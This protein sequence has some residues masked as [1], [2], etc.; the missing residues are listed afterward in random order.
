MTDTYAE[1]IERDTQLHEAVKDS[2][3]AIQALNSIQI[4][5]F[6]FYL[7]SLHNYYP[8][9]ENHTT[10]YMDF[11]RRLDELRNSAEQLTLQ[12]KVMKSSLFGIGLCV[13][14][15]ALLS[16]TV[17]AL[18]S[19]ENAVAVCAG[20]GA[21]AV[22]YFADSKFLRDA[23]LLSKEQDRKYFLSSI[24]MARA[25]NELDWAGLFTYH[26]AT[27]SGS[28]SD[29]DLARVQDAIGELTSNLRSALYNDEYFQYSD[30]KL[31][32]LSQGNA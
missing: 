25:C 4:E 18:T 29:A 28:H 16:V 11:S 24:R 5:K 15:G 1:C 31:S 3:P 8:R 22:I 17:L 14:A 7:K 27:K 10:F 23:I 32:E 12:R 19:H 21:I 13:L 6:I 26:K 9:S 2:L 30:P 20:M